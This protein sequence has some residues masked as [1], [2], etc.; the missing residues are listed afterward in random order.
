MQY[1]REIK[2][3]MDKLS[4]EVFGVKSKWRKMVEKGVGEL[5]EEDIKRLVI[6]DG[7]EEYET[8]KTVVLYKDQLPTNTLHRYTVQECKEFMIKVKERQE[9][10]RQA[11][12]QF[13]EQQKA[14]QEAEKDLKN[15][16]AEAAS[17]SSV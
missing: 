2:E 10:F 5:V 8:A 14:K 12:K 1:P 17:G 16:V 7:K 9:Q 15:A 11:F 13:E 6:K 3:E 4:L